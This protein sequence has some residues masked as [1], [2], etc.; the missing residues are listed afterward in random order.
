MITTLTDGFIAGTF[1][2]DLVSDSPLAGI[3]IL[4][5]Q[6]PD[7]KLDSVSSVNAQLSAARRGWAN[8]EHRSGPFQSIEISLSAHYDDPAACVRLMRAQIAHFGGARARGLA[9]A[10]CRASDDGEVLMASRLARS[11]PP[12]RLALASIRLSTSAGRPSAL[13]PSMT[14]PSVSL[15]T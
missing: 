10:P 1:A 15:S 6:T 5:F 2:T 8:S 3:S 4:I 12:K 9:F 11:R 14:I 7:F 13:A